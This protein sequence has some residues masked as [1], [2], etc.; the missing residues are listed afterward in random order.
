MISC[1]TEGVSWI[2][3]GRDQGS[4]WYLAVQWLEANLDQRIRVLKCWSHDCTH[5]HHFATV[6]IKGAQSQ[7]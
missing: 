3:E 7:I 6:V 2:V 1:V 5:A 4:L